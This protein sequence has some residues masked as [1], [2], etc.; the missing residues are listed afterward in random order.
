[1]K[2]VVRDNKDMELSLQIE[3]L[4]RRDRGKLVGFI[5]ERVRSKE[6]AEDIL[7]DVFANVLAAASEV[8]EP[9]ENL[10]SVGIYGNQEP[11]YRFLPQEAPANL[12]RYDL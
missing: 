1:M 3:N 9:I 2:T 4:F 12:Y 8:T 7:Q 10:G 5:R 6:E 11:D